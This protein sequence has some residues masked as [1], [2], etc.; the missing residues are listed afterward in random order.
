MPAKIR[1]IFF[2]AGNTLLYP[3]LEE[4]AQ[5]LSR[6]G[7]PA[8]IEDFYEAERTGKRALD[9]WL[10]PQIRSGQLP[11]VIDPYYWRAYLEF[12][13]ERV[14]VPSEKRPDLMKW[15]S[16]HFRN[17]ELWS[18][19]LPETVPSL[20]ELQTAGYYLGVISNSVGTIAQQ[21]D[22][23]GLGVYFES[24][25]DSAI[26]GVEKPNR[27]IFHMA[28]DRAQVEA[29]EAV[30]IGDTYSTDVGGAQ[31]AGLRGILMDRVGAYPDAECSR[32]HSLSELKNHL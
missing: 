10:W 28:L 18:R 3:R 2:D 29:S 23:A 31:L 5:A 14:G 24:V 30:F 12:L 20:A 8:E 19:V 27:E 1:A 13:T 9:E 25:L 21:L 32:V 15:I 4:V 22:R 6:L 11:K 17:I 26:V 16:S 7:F